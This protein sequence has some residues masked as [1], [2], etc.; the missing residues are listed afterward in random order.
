MLAGAALLVTSLATSIAPAYAG[1]DGGDHY[2]K[3]P[4]LSQKTDQDSFANFVFSTDYNESEI[5]DNAFRHAS[6]VMQ[7]NQATG[8]GNQQNNEALVDGSKGDSPAYA[9]KDRFAQD[10]GFNGV[11]D[12]NYNETSIEDNAFRH[13]SG[14]VQ[15]N[16]AA[17]NL[18]QNGNAAAITDADLASSKASVHQ[19]LFLNCVDSYA[20]NSATITDNAF[21]HFSGVAQINQASGDLNQNQNQLSVAK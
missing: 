1:E 17:G 10:A 21:R 5:E 6:G 13:A 16:Q 11:I 4:T 8:V 9:L 14:L 12:L 2:K 3:A 18:N 19:G 20:Y 7:I 15:I